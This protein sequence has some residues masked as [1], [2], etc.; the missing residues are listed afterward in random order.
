MSEE[1]TIAYMK[2]VE[3][4]KDKA[5]DRIATLEADLAAEKARWAEL[6]A[7]VTK[8]EWDNRDRY[9]WPFKEDPTSEG[10]KTTQSCVAQ[11][12]LDHMDRLSTPADVV[13]V[14]VDGRSTSAAAAVLQTESIELQEQ[15]EQCADPEGREYYR[16]EAAPLESIIMLL[17][18]IPSGELYLVRRRGD[19]G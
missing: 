7:F 5:R 14:V 4:G 10:I 8:L 16:D 17:R 18:K 19:H 12:I 13:R 15:A 3:D 1:L 9:N 11:R 2:G 6:K